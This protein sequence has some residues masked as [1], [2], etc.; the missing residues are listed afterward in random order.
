MKIH[1][2]HLRKVP[3][4]ALPIAV[5]ALQRVGSRK[6]YHRK[7]VENI[8]EQP[9]DS[10]QS[11]EHNW[12]AL[13]DCI[14]S[15]GEAVVGH[16]RK[17]QPDWFLDAADTL[18]LLLDEKYAALDRFLQVNSMSAKKEF[19]RHQREIKHAVDNAK[20]SAEWLAT[21]RKRRRMVVRD[22]CVRGSYR[23]LSGVAD[24]EDLQ[25]IEG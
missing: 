20:G 18:Q 12:M 6:V 11:V 5:H 23:W 16:G 14:V 10:D 13:K 8:S 2:P 4:R 7:I 25:C 22:G 1:L 24:H 9:H 17:K 15:A 19:R 3:S 21:Q